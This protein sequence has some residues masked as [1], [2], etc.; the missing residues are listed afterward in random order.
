VADR[1]GSAG[2]VVVAIVVAGAASRVMVVDALVG[3]AAGVPAG[4]AQLL[5]RRES[6]IIDREVRA[7]T[8]IASAN[9]DC[10]VG[11]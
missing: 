6:L 3:H 5:Q 7:A 9:A 8:N 1:T 11:G 2:L 10:H 4:T